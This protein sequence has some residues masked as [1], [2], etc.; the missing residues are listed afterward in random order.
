[1]GGRRPRR[2]ESR[3]EGGLNMALVVTLRRVSPVPVGYGDVHAGGLDGALDRA[4]QFPPADAL[5]ESEEEGE[6]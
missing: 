1:M 2:R 3:P 6:L 5:Y 4:W